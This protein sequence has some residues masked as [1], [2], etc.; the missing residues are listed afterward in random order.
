MKP[1]VI[2]T[3]LKC[4][5]FF[6]ARCCRS[7]TNNNTE[8]N[9]YEIKIMK[10]MFAQHICAIIHRGLV[11]T[12]L[13]SQDCLHI[14]LFTH[15]PLDTCRLNSRGRANQTQHS[16]MFT[17]QYTRIHK[18][19]QERKHTQKKGCLESLS[20]VDKMPSLNIHTS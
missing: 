19:M 14:T 8:S 15:R 17:C 4:I 6:V 1:V 2:R 16:L 11:Y 12:Y 10:F 5:S 7:C 3:S 13:D 20:L 9:E 18:C